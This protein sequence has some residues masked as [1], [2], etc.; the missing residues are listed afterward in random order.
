MS[1]RLIGLRGRILIILL[2]VQIGGLGLLMVFVSRNARESLSEMAYVSSQYLTR[3]SAADLERRLASAQDFAAYLAR[4]LQ[5]L[6]EAGL[7]RAEARLMPGVFLEANLGVHGAWAVFEPDAYDG[8]DADFAN[9]PSY[10]PTGLFAPY[11]FREG[12]ELSLR[13][14]SEARAGVAYAAVLRSSGRSYAGISSEGSSGRAL[15]IAVPILS[16]SAAIGAVGVEL[17]MTAVTA[18]ISGIKPFEGSV[19]FILG[20]DGLVAAHQNRALEGGDLSSAYQGKTL[21][22]LMKAINSGSSFAQATLRASDGAPVYL[23]AQPIRL[24]TSSLYWALVVDVPLSVILAPVA[25]LSAT[26]FA[27]AL[28]VF[29]LLAAA[30][31]ISLGSALK[32]LRLAATAIRDIAEGDADLTSEVTIK[33]NDEVGDLVADFNRFVRKLRE[34]VAQLKHAQGTVGAVGEELAASSHQTASAASEIMAN[35]E[36]VRRQAGLQ[37]R[38]V[39]DSSSS[40]EEVARNIESLERLITSQASSITEAS[41]SIEQMVGNIESV[42]ASIE[43]MAS[44][45]DALIASSEEGKAKQEAAEQRVKDIASR[46]EQLMQANDAIAAIASQTNLLAMNA[47]IEAAHAG[48]A[49]K[50]FAVVADEIRHLA[51]T[52]AEQS[53]SIGAELS[54]VREGITEVVKAAVESGAAFAGLS[55]GVDRTAELV[56]QIDRAM[57]EQREGSRQILE[58]LK[59]MNGVTSQVRSGASEMTGGNSQVLKAMRSLAELAQTIEGSM[60]E[61]AAGAKEISKAA[62]QVAELSIKTRGGLDEMEQ[63][64]GR[65]T[66]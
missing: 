56:R 42:S 62:Q 30:I 31:W 60:D 54:S 13:D 22:A 50:G 46:S 5:S 58:A 66:V 33:R 64:I 52:A 48:D 28:A 61:M 37:A 45:Y 8:R 19:A 59:E 44:S 47:A 12:E 1:S 36:G 57:H 15:T 17:S 24:G 40:V 25:K 32:P 23:I 63:S 65:F 41:A 7:E 26:L 27:M 10:G 51:E 29:V 16:R 18:A 2:L 11:W 14:F 38:S 21:E 3:G 20:T 53:R 4:S 9:A 34:I 6:K 49:G 43:K 39:E 35:V 55:T